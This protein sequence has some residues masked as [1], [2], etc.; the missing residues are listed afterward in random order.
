MNDAAAD[1]TRRAP[2]EPETRASARHAGGG[3]RQGPGVVPVD[4]DRRAPVRAGRRARHLLD[5]VRHRLRHL[6][7][8]RQERLRRQLPDPAQ[9]LEPVGPDR[10]DRG[11]GH[12]HGP[13]H[14]LA[15][16]RPLGRVAA[17]LP[18][19]GHGHH[20]EGDP[21][22]HHRLRERAHLD[23]RA[24]GRHRGGRGHR[25]GAG[26]HH[27]LSRGP[28]LHR[29]P[30]RSARLARRRLRARRGPDDRAAR[31]HVQ[32]DRR[33]HG[34]LARP[35][36]RGARPGVGDARLGPRLRDRAHP[37]LGRRPQ[38]SPAGGASAS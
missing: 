10:V 9:P 12:R 16:H 15:Q 28:G 18:R 31:Q 27:R 4:G 6:G 5:R 26:L 11:H 37:R 25:R 29:H 2:R 3:S 36:E 24:R 21:A 22:R 35:P 14:R 17:R 13:G 8:G 38:A 30:R 1:Q 32:Q 33:G 23:H 19:H 20:P 34:G 7:P